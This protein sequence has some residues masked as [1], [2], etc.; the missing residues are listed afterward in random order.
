MATT[1]ISDLCA[2][3]TLADVDDE[4][5]SMQIPDVPVDHAAGDGGYYAMCR[6]VTNKQIRFQ[7]FQD[8]MALVW[9]PAMGLTM[10]QLQPQRFLIRFYHDADISRVLAE[11][12]WTYEQCLLIMQRLQPG[13]D[14]ENVVLQFAEF[15]V[16]IHSL[17]TGFRSEIVVSAIGM[18]L[19]NLVCVDERNFDGG[20]RMFYRIRVAIDVSKPL[21]KQMKL[22]K[23][24]ATWAFIDF[25]PRG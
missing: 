25:R 22:K 14:P 21:K 11:G 4:D 7:F 20:M 19:G 1:D 6:V 13:E 12:P 23:G 9:Q 2:N 3:L 10:R 24:N 15:W 8:T 17:P 16:Q 5:G 18:F